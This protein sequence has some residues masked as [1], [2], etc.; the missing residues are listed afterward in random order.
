[1]SIA[2]HLSNPSSNNI[3]IITGNKVYKNNVENAEFGVASSN[4]EDNNVFSNNTFVNTRSHEF[5]CVED[6]KWKLRIRHSQIT[7]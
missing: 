2:F 5:I 7:V 1:M 6:R 4:T 3:R